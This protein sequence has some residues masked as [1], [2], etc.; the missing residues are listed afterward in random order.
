[1]ESGKA[2]EPGSVLRYSGT[3]AGDALKETEPVIFLSAPYL[4]LKERKR[5]SAAT[6][7][8]ASITLL[9]SLYGYDVGDGR[10]S[11]QVIEKIDRNLSKKKSTCL[12]CGVCWLV[13]VSCS[14]CCSHRLCKSSRS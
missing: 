12:S 14:L 5:R 2:L 13:Q 6:E 3:Y 11:Y 10:E 1:M 4:L 9:Q 8:F 7:D